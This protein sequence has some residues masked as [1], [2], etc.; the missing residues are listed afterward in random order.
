MQSHLNAIFA[1]TT[2]DV[3]S[4]TLLQVQDISVNNQTTGIPN[5]GAAFSVAGVPNTRLHQADQLNPHNHL[6]TSSDN[7]PNVPHHQGTNNFHVGTNTDTIPVS[8]NAISMVD[9]CLVLL[10]SQILG[11]RCY[12]DASIQPDQSV[13]APREAG[14]GIFLVNT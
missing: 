10:P 1:Q 14:I 8:N 11:N 4:E 13:S 6:N 7:L 3:Q 2:S 5:Q 12:V 9:R